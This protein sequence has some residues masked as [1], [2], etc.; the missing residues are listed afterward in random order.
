MVN[1]DK[2]KWQKKI[3]EFTTK[4]VHD[5]ALEIGIEIFGPKKFVDVYESYFHTLSAAL[6]TIKAFPELTEIIS[7]ELRKKQMNIQKTIEN[8]LREKERHI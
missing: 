7:L 2:K 6:L 8:I 5:D 1:N 3:P 4:Y